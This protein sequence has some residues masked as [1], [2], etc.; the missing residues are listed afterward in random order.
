VVPKLEKYHNWRILLSINVKKE[1]YLWYLYIF[2]FI[3]Y[4]IRNKYKK[5]Q[6]DNLKK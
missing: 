5:E 3:W 6:H 1:E 2:Q 4:I